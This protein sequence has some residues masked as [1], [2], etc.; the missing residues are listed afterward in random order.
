MN[1]SRRQSPCP[2]PRP[3]SRTL[4]RHAIRRIGLKTGL[5]FILNNNIDAKEITFRQKVP[6]E[7]RLERVQDEL[8]D[9][10]EERMRS[11]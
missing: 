6:Q 1:S 5:E 9:V 10:S 11:I 7:D 2:S 4:S 3:A 8:D